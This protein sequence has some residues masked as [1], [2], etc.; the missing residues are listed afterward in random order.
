MAFSSPRGTRIH[1]APLVED[2]MA[3][4]NDREVH[5]SPPVVSINALYCKNKNPE[6]SA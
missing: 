4:M 6:G 1:T 3:S 5:S 2:G